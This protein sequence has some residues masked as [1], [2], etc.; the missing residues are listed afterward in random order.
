GVKAIAAKVAVEELGRCVS[1]TPQ[2]DVRDTDFW[3]L[4]L[5]L[6]AVSSHLGGDREAAHGLLEQA[7]RLSSGVAPS[8]TGLCIAQRAMIAMERKDWEAAEELT[9]R[10]LVLVQE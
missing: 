7:C 10:A 1:A 6:R 8:L 3:P 2:S 9:D 5:L 4:C